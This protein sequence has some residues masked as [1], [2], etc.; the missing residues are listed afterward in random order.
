MYEVLNEFIRICETKED[1]EKIE[2]YQEI[3]E[4]LKNGLNENGWD[5]KWFRRAYFENA[6]K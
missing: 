6:F 3:M 2:E 4:I 5:G 1:Y